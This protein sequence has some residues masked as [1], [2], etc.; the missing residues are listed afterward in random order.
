MQHP[1]FSS[2]RIYG[3][4]IAVS[5]LLMLIVINLPFKVKPFG[6]D[7]FHVEAKNLALYLK[8]HVSYGKVLISK[9]PGPVLFYAVPYLAAPGDATDNQLWY[10]GVLFTSILITIA[11]ILIFRIGSSFFSKEIGILSVLLFFIFPIHCYYTLGILAEGPA[12]FS[13][14]LAVYGWSVVFHEPAKTKGWI[15]FILGTWFLILNRPNAMLFLGIGGLVV[16]YA[17]FANKAFF[18]KW[19]KKLLVS[20]FVVGILGFGALQAAKAITRGKTQQNQEN[21]LYYLAHQGRFQFR[22]EPTDLRYWESDIRPDSKDYQN[23]KKNGDRL[24]REIRLTHRSYPEVY[25]EFLI[26]DAIEHPFWFTRQFF[27]KCLYGHIYIINSVQP[28]NFHLG[29]FKGTNGYMVFMLLINLVNIIIVAGAVVFLV[30][31]KNLLDYWIFW[32]IIISLLIFQ[33]LTYME[34]RYIFPSKVTLYLM[35]AAGLYRIGFVKKGVDKFCSFLF[36][37]SAR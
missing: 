37:T 11:L 26:D 8:G 24:N 3:F 17:W 34:P 20:L 9:A 15:F 6:D 4:I 32:G 36:Y 14:A 1:Q 5:L 23:W 31:Q 10:Y 13:L 18:K 27:I 19:G 28:E 7:T 25:K 30:R 16:F 22:E 29:P 33:G 12:F 2:K 21:L 35:S